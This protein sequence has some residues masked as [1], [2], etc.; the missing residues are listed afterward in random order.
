MEITVAD[1]PLIAHKLT[2]LRD[3]NTN[4]LQFRQLMDELVLLLA[5]SA[6]ENLELETRPTLTPMGEMLGHQ[7]KGPL[8]LILPILRAGLGMLPAMTQVLP[9]AQVGLLGIK[10]DENTL[11]PE[12]YANRLP[13]DLHGR[14]ILLLDP[15]LATGGTVI[16]SLDYVLDHGA[17]AVTC[18]FLL[19]APEGLEAVSRHVSSVWKDRKV[20]LVLASIDEKLNDDAFIMPGLG[21]A[22][23]RL[24]GKI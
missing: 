10:R 24:F 9:N 4:Q 20:R 12:I 8:P 11:R 14:H 7:V 21:D 17:N 23:D 16:D 18:L 19:A 2:L 22:G 1:H 6:T 13:Q 3:A 15:M 5:Y